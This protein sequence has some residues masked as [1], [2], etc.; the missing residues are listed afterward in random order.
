MRCYLLATACGLVHGANSTPETVS[1]VYG[2]SSQ[3]INNAA[4][5]A[6]ECYSS[7]ATGNFDCTNFIKN[8]L[9]GTMDNQA[10]CPFQDGMCRSNQ[11]TLFLD[12]GYLDSREHFGLNTPD[13]DRIFFRTTMHCA[14]LN[15]EGFSKNV[16]TP[17]NNY[18][19]YFYGPYVDYVNYTFQTED[20]DAQYTRAKDNMMYSW[21]VELG[22]R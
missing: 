15:T 2:Y 13:S 12:S 18:T 21:N 8:H 1:A 22:L 10:G 6:Q 14:P 19:Q 20:M 4:N 17:V 9:P 16:S 7:D 5:Y 11:S 3:A